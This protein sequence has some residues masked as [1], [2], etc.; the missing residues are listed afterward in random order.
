M[1]RFGIFMS[2]KALKVIN[3]YDW[4]WKIFFWALLCIWNNKFE[5]KLQNLM[6][7]VYNAMHKEYFSHRPNEHLKILSLR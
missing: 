5:N 6:Q 2:F 1:H 4:K 3:V 7:W